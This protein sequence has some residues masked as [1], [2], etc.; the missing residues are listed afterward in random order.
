MKLRIKKIKRLSA[1]Q[2]FHTVWNKNFNNNINKND[3]D[4]DFM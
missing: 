3:D 2:I 4:I 1:S